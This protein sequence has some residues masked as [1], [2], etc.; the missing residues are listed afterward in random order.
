MSELNPLTNASDPSV[1]PA[2]S[3][4]MNDANESG[5]GESP[6]RRGNPFA[7]GTDRPA[8]AVVTPMF[9]EEVWVPESGVLQ[10]SVLASLIVLVFSLACWRLFPAGGILVTGLGCG[11]SILGMFSSRIVAAA[12]CLIAHAVLF[13]ACYLLVV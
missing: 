10:A 13:V 4:P 12:M 6:V 1:D 7:S 11:L 9:Q 5:N 2:T 8:M 3:S